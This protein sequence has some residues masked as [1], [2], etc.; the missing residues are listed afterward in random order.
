MSATATRQGWVSSDGFEWVSTQG[1]TIGTFA[2]YPPNS[3]E[4]FRV[5][6]P[7]SNH[8]SNCRTIGEAIEEAN[9]HLA[10]CGGGV[11]L[12]EA[13]AVLIAADRRLRAAQ[14]EALFDGDND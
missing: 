14:R 5:S 11:A 9:A 4:A 8:V 6:D 1:Y 10:V 7:L 13:A 3:H 2:T 12:G